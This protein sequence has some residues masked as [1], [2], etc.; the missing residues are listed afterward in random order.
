MYSV[1]SMNNIGKSS[2]RRAFHNA[3]GTIEPSNDIEQGTSI[4]HNHQNTAI[5]QNNAGKKNN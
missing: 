1:S 4:Q 5:K 3:D 2:L